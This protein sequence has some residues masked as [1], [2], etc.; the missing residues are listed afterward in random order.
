MS[1]CKDN[2]HQLEEWVDYR[3]NRRKCEEKGLYE[4][5]LQIEEH[6]VSACDLVNAYLKR[7]YRLW[8]DAGLPSYPS[9]QSSRIEFHRQASNTFYE[10]V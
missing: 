2:K 10:L 5:L 8:L 4:F 3:V 1:A 6:S 7:F 9:L